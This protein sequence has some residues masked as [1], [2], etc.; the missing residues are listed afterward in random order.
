MRL[1]NVLLTNTMIAGA[2]AIGL[3]ALTAGT[4]LAQ[5]VDVAVRS[6]TASVDP[7][8]SYV[9]TNKA[10]VTHIFDTLI[11][12]DQNLQLV[13]GLATDWT[14]LG[15]G[16]WEL[17]LREGVTW[18][19]GEPFTADD[20]M[21]TFER[22]PNV[23]NSPAPFGQFLSQIEDAVVVDDH[24]IHITTRN[25]SPQL[26]FDL[27]EVPIISR[28]AGEGAA[29]EDYNSGAA[30]IGTGPFRFV[31]WT[32]GQAIELV[33]NDDYWAGPAAYE[34][35]NL[36]AIPNDATRVAA[37]L[38]GD[39]DL[40]D[41][42]PPDSVE[43]LENSDEIDVWMIPD[44]YTAYL[45][46]DTNRTDTPHITGSDGEPIDNPLLNRDVREALSL[47][48]D[49][50]AI[51]DRLLHGLGRPAGQLAGEFMVG[52][53]PEL[54][55]GAY[56]PDRARELLADAGYPDGF[57]MTLHGP[58][59]R[60][61]ADGDIAQAIAQMFERIG[62]D[63]EVE[64]MPSNVFFPS[65]SNLDFSIFFIAWGS[66]QG[67]AW[68]GLRGVLMTHDAEQGYGPSNRGRYSNA[69]VDR[70]TIA[71]M[72]TFDLDEAASLSAEAAALAFNDYA[73]IPLHYQMNVWAS[74]DG[75]EYLP[76]QDQM[77][78]AYGL[79]LDD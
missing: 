59:N 8:F 23:P 35:L 76:R 24:T 27:A 15:D 1:C 39:V 34:S 25:T 60:Y 79:T 14:H 17:S 43:M 5:H 50:E 49:R 36:I 2:T 55:P 28:H 9:A 29:T 78:L 33:R 13:P 75:F 74:R 31:S 6:E 38:S 47:A 70:L 65:A 44:V 51:I 64:T 58:N 53:N 7:H 52:Y 72:S 77:T 26:L 68:H 67:T 12:R 45:H 71:S 18:H 57:S 32:P 54:A 48:I 42:V 63:M 66:A 10:A 3:A 61:V 30:T 62:V 73:I 4:A 46:M 22:A 19:D 69:D 41:A 16:V 11:Q 21:F 20:V 56:D 37:L 40:I